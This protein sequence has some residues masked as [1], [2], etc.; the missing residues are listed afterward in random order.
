LSNTDAIILNMNLISLNCNPRRGKF[1]KQAAINSK[2][3]E[4]K[5]ATSY[6]PI[7]IGQQ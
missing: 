1:L 2:E 6:L 3:K 4:T 7:S 5:R